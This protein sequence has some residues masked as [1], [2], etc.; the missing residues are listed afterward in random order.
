MEGALGGLLAPLALVLILHPLIGN[1]Y[2]LSLGWTVIFTVFIVIMAQVGDLVESAIKRKLST[3]DSGGIIPGH[4]GGIRG[5]FDGIIFAAPF[6]HY[7]LLV[8][9]LYIMFIR[10]SASR[11]RIEIILVPQE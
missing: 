5:P 7:F 1:Y 8:A 10:T 9:Q 3:K 6:A 2:P 11:G 4:G